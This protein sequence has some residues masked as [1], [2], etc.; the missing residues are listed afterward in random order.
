MNLT[1]IVE[2]LA[3]LKRGIEDAKSE[4]LRIDGREAEALKQLKEV[5]QLSSIEEIDQKL[6]ELEQK[7]KELQEEIKSLYTELKELYDW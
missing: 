6:T 2:S 5:H 3:S 1:P 4:L 7:D